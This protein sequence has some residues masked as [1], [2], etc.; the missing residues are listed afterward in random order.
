[1]AT[2]G[3]TADTRAQALLNAVEQR[4]VLQPFSAEQPDLSLADAYAI[5]SRTLA[6][7]LQSGDRQIG[8]KVGL[9][10][11]ATQAE[12]GLH[13]PIS[14]YLLDSALWRD[15]A[16]V[17]MERFIALRLEPEIAFRLRRGLK[18]P[19]VT[20][21]DVAQATEG[22][23]AAY[24]L[25]DSRF[26]WHCTPIDGVADNSYDAGAVIG[27]LLPLADVDLLLEQVTV[28]QNGKTVAQAT[29]AAV[30]GDPINAVVWLAN[31]L[32][33]R[34]AELRAGDYVLTGSLTRILTPV[35]GNTIRASFSRLGSIALRFS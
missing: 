13:E 29:G 10:S 11:A 25:V 12:L 5:Q 24:E 34:G 21:A 9:T 2:T 27:P 4:S 33:T 20:A 32:P 22:V 16:T 15:G 31:H 26:N 35:P 6:A 8:W 28:E 3:T 18:G 23:A 17:P 7:R 14:G 1:M 30:M 19:G